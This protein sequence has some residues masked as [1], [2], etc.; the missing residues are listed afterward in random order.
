M[1]K[2]IVV[3]KLP[4][5]PIEAPDPCP[6]RA[7]IVDEILANPNPRFY[8]DKALQEEPAKVQRFTE[9]KQLPYRMQKGQHF[10]PTCGKRLTNI[11]MCLWRCY[12]CNVS[13]SDL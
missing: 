7:R 9:M 5:V 8:R 6:L 2:K 4:T 11:A 10:C 13:W 12:P 3:Q 1:A